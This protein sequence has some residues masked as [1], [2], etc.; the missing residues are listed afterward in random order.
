MSAKRRRNVSHIRISLTE[1]TTKS[2]GTPGSE[3]PTTAGSQ[4]EQKCQ[5]Q[6]DSAGKI[7]HSRETGKLQGL[8]VSLTPAANLPPGLL[9]PVVANNGNKIRLITP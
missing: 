3:R 7:S 9:I 8:Q 2:A 1:G 6:N 4:K 5:Q